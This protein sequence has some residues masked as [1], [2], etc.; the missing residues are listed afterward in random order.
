MEHFTDILI[1]WDT[2]LLLTLNALHTPYFDR[3]M[4]NV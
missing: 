4:M 1:Q 2:A 3:F